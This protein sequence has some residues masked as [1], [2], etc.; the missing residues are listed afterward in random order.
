[1]N[2]AL[3][4]SLKHELPF[5]FI[6]DLCQ[7]RSSTRDVIDDKV[8]Q[9][10]HKSMHYQPSDQHIKV[11][12]IA[13]LEKQVLSKYHIGASSIYS[14]EIDKV[15]RIGDSQARLGS[16]TIKMED[17]KLLALEKKS[18]KKDQQLKKLL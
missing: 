3:C 10:I 16:S 8:L 12:H 9:D 2:A 18:L 17:K 4:Y 11:S 1:M 7:I 13:H 6:D 15:I 14:M 5:D